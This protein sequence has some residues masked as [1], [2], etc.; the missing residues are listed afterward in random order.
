M[1]CCVVGSAS[2]CRKST[3][4]IV[5]LQNQRRIVGP[6]IVALRNQWI[7]G[8]TNVALRGRN[9]MDHW[10]LRHHGIS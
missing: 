2:H 5:V 6:T 3:K 7:V 8:Q 10:S 1:D 9:A 4:R